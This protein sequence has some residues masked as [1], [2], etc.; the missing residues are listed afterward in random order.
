[1]GVGPLRTVFLSKNAVIRKLPA[2]EGAHGLL[3]RAIGCG[4]R[5][6]APSLLVLN[7]EGGSKEW[8][9]GFAGCSGELIDEVTEVD[10]GHA[11]ACLW[12][13]TYRRLAGPATARLDSPVEGREPFDLLPRGLSLQEPAAPPLSHRH[14]G[15][16]SMGRQ[17]CNNSI[18]KRASNLDF[19]AS[20]CRL[21]QCG[22]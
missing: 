1:F 13:P 17:L 4:H 14:A 3:G 15:R 12:F 11:A 21:L 10:G 9:D 19:C 22:S 2:D 7:S 18:G 5:I 8:Q 16:G 20:R 6:K